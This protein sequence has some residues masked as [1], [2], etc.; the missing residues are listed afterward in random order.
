MDK[1]NFWVHFDHFWFCEFEEL[2]SKSM[3]FGVTSAFEGFLANHKL[4]IEVC[5]WKATPIIVDP[6]LKPLLVFKP[7]PFV[8]TMRDK[9]EEFFRVAIDVVYTEDVKTYIHVPLVEISYVKF[10]DVLKELTKDDLT[11]F[12]K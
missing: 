11:A 4:S 2:L 9:D 12:K 5:E 8:A 10:H 1:L 3:F 6:S 7:Y